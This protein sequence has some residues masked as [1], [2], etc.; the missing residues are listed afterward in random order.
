[1]PYSRRSVLK[2]GV[3]VA[4]SPPQ[5]KLRAAVIGAGAFGGWTALHLQRRGAQVTLIDAWGPGNSRASSGGE[6]RIIRATY[7]PHRLYVQMVVRSLTLWREHEKRWNRPL[8]RQVGC[9]RMPGKDDRSERAAIPLMREAGLV[10]EELTPG[11]ARRRWP[12][13]NFE[14]LRWL[15]YEKDAGFLTARRNCEAVL[16]G[17]LREGGSY[18]QLS[19]NPGVIRGGTMQ[20]LSLSDGSQ[21]VA[22]V[23]VFACGPWIGKLLPEVLGERM[24]PTRQEVLFFGTAAGD[25]RFLEGH[26]PVWID[27]GDPHFYGIPGNEWRGFKIAD[28]SRGP[29]FDPTS[30]DRTPTAERIR[31][32]REYLTFRF[33]GMK[34]APLIES[35]VCQYENSPDH[36]FIID[37]H[38]GARNVWLVGG[39]S[40]HGYKMGPA[41]GEHVSELVLG[42]RAAEPLFALSRF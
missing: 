4:V 21:L 41:V 32:A 13:L 9:I 20:H 29:A 38:P 8:Y 6:T 22:D 35:R 14:G 1:M 33:P 3:A 18:K 40:G 17:F 30:G 36:H 12:Q 5:N 15:L 27:S 39:G 23:Y 19:A 37:R 34:G 16:G 7:G 11:E 26:L 10:V 42:K 28:D 31:E 2:A 25:Q 24:Q